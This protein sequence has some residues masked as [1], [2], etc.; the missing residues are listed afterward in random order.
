M[1]LERFSALVDEAIASIPEDFR[2]RLD[3]IAI[4]IQPLA[5]PDL[6]RDLSKNPWGL[7]G[8]YQGVPYASRGPWY[9]NV[10]PDRILIFQQP[11]ERQ[12]RTAAEIRKLVRRVVIHEV[13][14]Y[15]GLTDDALHE[16]EREADKAEARRPASE[17]GPEESPSPQ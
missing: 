6:Y 9:G 17:E 1:E 5:A 15:F 8:V 11:I 14:H 13:G 12:A 10:L 16:L 4:Q 2:S 7:L 3:N